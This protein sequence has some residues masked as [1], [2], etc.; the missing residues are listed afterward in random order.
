MDKTSKA[1]DLTDPRTV[2]GISENQIRDWMRHPV[3]KLYLE[4]LAAMRVGHEEELMARWRAGSL[5]LADEKEAM[6]RTRAL[7]ILEQLSPGDFEEVF[8]LDQITESSEENH[9]TEDFERI[10]P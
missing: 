4:M 9:E 3:T 6:G 10:I 2:R 8:G 7:L 1:P 5:V